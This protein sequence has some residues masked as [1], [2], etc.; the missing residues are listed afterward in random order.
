MK[1]LFAFVPLLLATTLAQ[2]DPVTF[3]MLRG[4]AAAAVQSETAADAQFANLPPDALPLTAS[5]TL[6]DATSFVS[7]SALVADGL[8]STQAEGG[9][10][11][12]FTSASSVASYGGDFV[13][14]SR[15]LLLDFVLDLGDSADS[16]AFGAS[17][18]VVTLLQNGLPFYSEVFD[19]AGVVSR[20]IDLMAGATYSL[21]V[22]ASSEANTITGGNAFA[23]MLATVQVSAVPEP[24]TIA[25]LLL[26]GTMLALARRRR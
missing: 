17:T 22:V 20:L 13:G 25:L 15:K 18:L 24:S 26:A 10:D 9:S 1:N 21:D 3:T 4:Q 5:T 12:G 8:L 14:A 23:S 16:Q 11:T 2:A 19:T 7:A 6:F